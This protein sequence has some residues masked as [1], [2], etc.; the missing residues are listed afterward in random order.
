ML[1]ANSK[2][3]QRGRKMIKSIQ[4]FFLFI[5]IIGGTNAFAYEELSSGEKTVSASFKYVKVKVHV[6]CVETYDNLGEPFDIDLFYEKS[7]FVKIQ[8]LEKIG[9][10]G[11]MLPDDVICE[12]PEHGG[13]LPYVNVPQKWKSTPEK[14]EKE[15]ENVGGLQEVEIAFWNAKAYEKLLKKNL[16]KAKS[17]IFNEK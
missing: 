11:R 17:Q 13:T 5:F 3:D 14:I 1:M 8:E 16:N 7:D 10:N 12:A 2:L 9:F 6:G 4:L 15:L